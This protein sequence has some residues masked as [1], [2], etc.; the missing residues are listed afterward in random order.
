MENFNLQMTL[1]LVLTVF[2]FFLFIVIPNLIE[3]S[4]TAFGRKR[5]LDEKR[6]FYIR[7]FLSVSA[8]VLLLVILVILWGIDLKG[9][10]IFASS[11]FALVGI[12]LFASWSILSNIT[13]GIILFFS[14]PFKIG[15]KVR[16]LAGD[17]SVEGRIVDMTLFLIK[18][19]E[20]NGNLISYPNN[21]AIQKPIVVN[22]K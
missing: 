2:F 9:I 19:E 13:A 6:V 1:Q 11:F 20:E 17:D 22:P 15:D 4:S 10:L 18:I 14:F 12:A 16:I 21:L 7:K 5:G 8:V 3:R